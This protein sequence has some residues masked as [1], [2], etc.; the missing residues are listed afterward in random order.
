V[1]DNYNRSVNC[2]ST[3]CTCSAPTSCRLL[4]LDDC[5]RD[6]SGNSKL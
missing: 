3:A 1:R 5:M 6:V 4:V 2:E